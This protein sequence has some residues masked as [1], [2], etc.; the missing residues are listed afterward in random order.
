MIFLLHCDELK[1]CPLSQMP[2][3]LAG[4]GPSPRSLKLSLSGHIPASIMPT[5]ISSPLVEY[6]D[7]RIQ[8]KKRKS[9]RDPEIHCKLGGRRHLFDMKT[10][11]VVLFLLVAVAVSVCGAQNCGSQASG[12][13][14]S[15]GECCSKWGW[16]GTTDEHCLPER[17]CQSNCRGGGGEKAYNVRSTYHEYY[18]ERHNWDLYAVSAYCSTWDGGRPLWWRQKYGWTAFCGP[19]GARGQGSCGKCLLV[20]NRETRSQAT[21]RI[22]D[23]CSNGG[24]DLDVNVFKQ[25]DTNGQGVAR[26]HLM[27]DYEFV[28]CGDGLVAEDGASQF[29]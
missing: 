6:C 1:A 23:Q 4:T 8:T 26:G 13:T 28:N 21:V 17:G 22:F 19:V 2:F 7:Q 16:C 14:C 25:L 3:H 12:R 27:V 18:P 10:K 24:L 15:G 29:L 9:G 20:T 5:I 11:A